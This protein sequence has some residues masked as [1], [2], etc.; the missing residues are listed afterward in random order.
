MNAN[1]IVKNLSKTFNNA[2]ILDE[3]N[4]NLI[5]G[6][7]LAIIGT[8]GSGKSVLLKCILGLIEPNRGSVIIDNINI[9]NPSNK[10]YQNILKKI[11]VTFQ[12]NALFDSYSIF[13]NVI[14]KIKYEKKYSYDHLIKL[15]ENSL[16]MVGLDKSIFNLY[17]SQ[18]S[19]GMQK[20]IA[21]AR[22]IIDQPDFLFFDEPTTGLDPINSNIINKLIVDNVKRLGATAI[23]ITHDFS[24]LK[25]IA[26]KIVLVN[27]GKIE[28]KGNF[29]LIQTSTN[30]FVRKFVNATK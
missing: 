23:T 29:K 9:S 12:S 30:P 16:H 24:S 11:G 22:A 28:W 20:R 13:E 7:S 19:G 5:K 2:K 26:D 18:L 21:I 14:F 8:S 6:E 1:L 27:N 17:P 3:I 25:K 4:L 15:A 10:Q